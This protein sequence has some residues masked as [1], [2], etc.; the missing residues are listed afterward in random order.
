VS[1]PRARLGRLAV[2]IF[3][4]VA[5]AAGRPQSQSLTAALAAF[6]DVWQTIHDTYYD[7][8]FNGLDWAAV[9]A[10]LRP[11]A[12]Q[13]AT[14][15]DVR[16]VINEMLSRLG[17]SH[18]VLLTSS[19]AGAPLPG[20]AMAPIDFRVTSDGVVV[21][22][23]GAAPSQGSVRP[24]DAIV[25]IDGQDPR[26]E[27]QGRD[28]PARR[29]DVWRRAFRALHGADGSITRLTLRDL[30]GVERA[31]EMIRAPKTGAAVS[32]GNLP[33]LHVRVETS[34]VRTAG[35]RRVGV[36]AFN[37]WMAAA[38]EPIARAI[39]TFRQADGIVIDLRGNTGGLADMIR[40]VA[41]HFFDEPELLGRLEMRETVLEFRAN[42][43]RSTSDGRRVAPYAGPLAILVDEQTA[44]ASECF[45]GALQS[46]GR[47]RIVGR[48]TMGQALPAATRQL[49]NGDVL[50]YAVGDFTTATGVRLEARGVA[51]DE[52][53]PLR[54][55][56][57]YEGR[58]EA[59]ERA[60]EWIDRARATAG[61]IPSGG[62]PS[63]AAGP[64]TPAASSEIGS[65]IVNVEPRPGS[66]RHSTRPL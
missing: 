22:R 57:L 31:A 3:A 6:D 30:D 43:R 39:D 42:P 37:A 13:A 36:V 32:L 47:A 25:S 28:E 5:A 52:L 54:R 62:S 49:P 9:R 21:T 46:L 50:M 45:A 17:E 56:A 24:G 38:A 48:R 61:W 16:R 19:A 53:V 26:R 58:D 64:G 63:A 12:A 40:G 59:L 34:D 27:P 15:D 66:L 7:P 14:A 1:V 44:S 20:E 23:V 11:R 65:E 35:G 10:E 8:S 60:L 41:G 4:C 33:Q 2:V 51:P 29:L 18:F 55:Q